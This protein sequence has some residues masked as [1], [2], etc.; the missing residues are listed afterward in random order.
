VAMT[1]ARDTLI[2]T[3]SIFESRWNKLWAGSAETPFNPIASATSVADW[4]GLWFSRHASIPLAERASLNPRESFVGE[5]K[6]DGHSLARWALHDDALLAAPPLSDESQ[7]PPAPPAFL[8]DPTQAQAIQKKLAWTYPFLTAVR[9]TAKSSVSLLRREAALEGE[10]TAQHFDF[11]PPA[12]RIRTGKAMD[13]GTATH[14]FLQRI[15]LDRAGSA[16]ELRA[17][18]ARLVREKS[19]STESAALI[20]IEQVTRFWQSPLGK[21]V[22]GQAG[23][24]Q[25]ELAFTAKIQLNELPSILG[26]ENTGNEVD[27]FVIVQ[28]IA[29]VVLLWPQSIEI[30]DFKTDS[31]SG[32]ALSER[33]KQYEPQLKLYATALARIYKRPVSGCWI[34]FLAAGEEVRVEQ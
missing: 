24:V 17:E 6:I 33:A 31:V 26:T 11:R 13:A 27:D 10:E 22:R 9:Q 12:S 1:R 23:Y 21:K 34:Y 28:G 30:I 2:L 7:S 18:A 14:T 29:D 32:R 20:N 4:L 8:S 25:R 16:A 19:L 5:V 15:T 3:S